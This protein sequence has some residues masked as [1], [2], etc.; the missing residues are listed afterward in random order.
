MIAISAKA[1]SAPATA[2]ITMTHGVEEPVACVGDSVVI[3]D[4]VIVG[5]AA[6]LTEGVTVVDFGGAKVV[7]VTIT[8]ALVSVIALERT[9]Q[10]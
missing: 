5:N 4:A 3:G 8:Q 10:K 2:A 9:L 1:N 6:V 7:N